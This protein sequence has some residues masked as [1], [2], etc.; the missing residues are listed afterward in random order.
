LLGQH[1]GNVAEVARAMGKARMQIH[2]WV[3]RL[4]IDPGRYRP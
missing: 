4:G 3:K 1:E 2:R